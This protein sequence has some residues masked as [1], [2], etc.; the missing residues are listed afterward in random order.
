MAEET[1]PN[2]RQP[3]VDDK[4][5]GKGKDK[6]RN[7]PFVIRQAQIDIETAERELEA[8]KESKSPSRISDAE[9]DLK[10]KRDVLAE[11]RKGKPEDRR[12]ARRDQAQEYYD[13]LGPYIVGLVKNV[14]ELRDTVQEAIEN[15]WNI[16]KF[17]RDRRVV[18]WLGT[19]GAAAKE[20]I[21]I[22]FDPTQKT[23]WEEK[24]RDARNA[25]K[26]LARGAYN[27]DL[28]DENLDRLARRYIYEGWE[29]N[30]RELQ[31]WMSE[32]VERGGE[33]TETITGGTIDSNESDL[34][35]LARNYGITKTDRWFADRARDMLN[36]DS[37]ITQEKLVND[38][39]SEAQGL[40]SVF[41]DRINQNFSVRDA[42]NSYLAQM[43]RWLEIDPEEIDLNDDLLTRAFT[44]QQDDKGEP[45]LMSL[46]EFQKAA[47]ADPRWQTTDNAMTTY[48]QVGENMLKM[49]GFRG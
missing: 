31:V 13:R 27:L 17:L 25:V 21:A 15:G 34:R 49:F 1:V 3:R 10:E 20:A 23:T 29:N 28:T 19:K 2:E 47:R 11:L 45:K 30:P 9:D 43:S 18:E 40:Y 41:G 22:E 33:R 8:A 14:P 42:A 32:R 38:M 5:K 39:I 12:E 7:V 44:T 26:D 16:D 6:E 36:P 48:T 4:D 37:G 46:W 35:Q 24:L